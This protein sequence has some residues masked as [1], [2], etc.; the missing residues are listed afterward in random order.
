MKTIRQL[1]EDR[2]WT[3]VDLAVKIDVAP[4]TIYNWERGKFEPRVSQLRD[5]AEVFG[6]RMDEIELLD[7]VEGKAAPVAA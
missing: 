7:E 2:G 6:V 4:S 1:R 3:Q 5:L